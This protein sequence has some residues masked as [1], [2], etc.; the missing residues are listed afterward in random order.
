MSAKTYIWAFCDFYLINLQ[1]D[2]EIFPRFAIR[3]S[4]VIDKSI[5]GKSIL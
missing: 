4:A 1:F 2:I 3:N 5:T